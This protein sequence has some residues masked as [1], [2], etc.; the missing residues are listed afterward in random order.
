MSEFSRRKLI[1]T[2]IAVTACA[3]G[4]AVAAKVAQ[5]YG[6]IRQMPAVSTAR[7]KH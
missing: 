2:S 3:S 7:A 6:L 1:T 5:R 4:L